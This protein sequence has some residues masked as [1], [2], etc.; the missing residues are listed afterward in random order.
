VG[1]L[2]SFIDLNEGVNNLLGSMVGAGVVGASALG[3]EDADAGVI[4]GSKKAFDDL[5]SSML[6]YPETNKHGDP[7]WHRIGNRKLEKPVEAYDV[8]RESIDGALSDIPDLDLDYL[9]D[10]YVISG[11]G[12]RQEAGTVIRGLDDMDFENPVYTQG[13]RDWMH[14][15]PDSAWASAGGEIKKIENAAKKGYSQSPENGLFMP[16]A[17]GPRGVDFATQTTDTMFQMIRQSDISDATKAEFDGEMRAIVPDWKGIDDASAHKQLHDVGAVRHAFNGLVDKKKYREN[18]FPDIAGARVAVTD[19][20]QLHT[21]TLSTGRR[22]AELTGG[23]VA[24]PTMKHDAYPVQLAGSAKGDL[25]ADIPA[26]MFWTDFFDNRRANNQPTQGDFRA[27]QLAPQGQLMTQQHI[28]NIGEFIDKSKSEK[29]SIDPALL[30]SLAGGSGLV[31]T[32]DKWAAPV[33]DAAEFVFDALEVP[34]RGW[35]GIAGVLGELARSGDIES[36]LAN[37]GKYASQSID[38][39]ASDYGRAVADETGSPLAAALTHALTQMA[40]PI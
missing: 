7:L 18:G 15:Q 30:S 24:E 19:P 17:M 38:D 28:D 40:N 4:N 14:L 34:V 21:P 26:Q 29:G 31:A 5:V 10:R 8:K 39:T 1:K 2:S 12:D 37:G 3:S 16:V 11:L 9:Q 6:H 35:H 36:A 33:N 23:R 27:L 25:G 20:D 13:G 22:V 32:A